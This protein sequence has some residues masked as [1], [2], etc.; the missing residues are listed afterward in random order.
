MTPEAPDGPGGPPGVAAERPLRA[1]AR[2]NR[3]RV[4][5]AADAVFAAKG[6]GAST[7]EVAREAGVGIGTVFRHF[8]TKE[9]LLTAVLVDRLRRLADEAEA[10]ADAEDPGGAFFGFFAR[11]VEQGRTK[12][13]FIDLLRQAGAD[14]RAETAAYGAR[15]T[16]AVAGLLVRAQRAGAVREDAG[17]AEVLALMAGSA[18]AA[19]HAAFD[20]EVRARALA[21]VFD[22]L[23]P[24]R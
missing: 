6:A 13:T 16:A 15:V 5:R 11:V 8:P 19:E 17:V 10:L 20:D 3:A 22:G 2:R 21:I 1:D 23:R 14:V 9:A 24:A 12:T 4:L 18:R 7:E